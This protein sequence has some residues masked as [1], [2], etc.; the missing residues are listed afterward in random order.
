M[1][2][3]ARLLAALT[4]LMLIVMFFVPMWRIDLEAPQYP[5]GL[6]ILITLT[7]V[8]GLNEFDLKNINQLNHYIGMQQIVPEAIPE[9]K[10]MPWLI[11]LMIAL[12]GM[13]AITGSRT[14]LTIWMISFVVL[15][16][17]GLVDFWLWEY[18]YGHNLDLENAA[19]KVPGMS[20][21][22]PLI[23]SKQLL[24]FKAHSWP[25]LGGWIAIL[26]VASSVLLWWTSRPKNKKTHGI[27]TAVA[28][29]L[30]GIVT[31]TSGCTPGP[32]AFQFGGDMGAWCRMPISD[33]RFASQVVLTTGRTVKFD[34]IE[35]MKS[36]LG[37]QDDS[38]P[39]IHSIWVSDATGSGTLIP[40]SD[41]V[42]AYHSSIRSP[43]GGSLAAFT[44]AESAHSMLRTVPV[45]DS[46]ALTLMSWE[47]VTLLAD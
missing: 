32:E 44:T 8:Q 23:G 42:F 9:L 25:A 46:A 7:D 14:L 45:S 3:R 35:C 31:L 37:A 39:P 13:T 20:Y 34:S 1:T 30:L 28:T 40:A 16:F 33:V 22:P 29:V 41:A 6:G 4:G 43:M 11:G 12:A 10:I 38:A 36:W 15:M 2:T 19:I 24:N 5:E 17:A 26:S 18:D 27:K 21:Q 47:D